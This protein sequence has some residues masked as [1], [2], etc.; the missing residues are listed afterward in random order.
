MTERE[1][2]ADELFRQGY[3]CAQAVLAAFGDLTGMEEVTALKLS[4][5]FGGGIGRLREGC[6]AVSGMVMA[7]GCLYGYADS[8][9]PTAKREHYARIQ[10]LAARFREQN[11][12]IVCRELL[13]LSDAAT[14]PEP[15]PR[16]AEFYHKRP[17]GAYVCDAVRILEDYIAEHPLG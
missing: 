11:G 17:C 15:T 12:A 3:N 6:G 7:A 5:S 16:T 10:Q 8:T 4:S 1:K 13:N 9:D 14:S 2:R